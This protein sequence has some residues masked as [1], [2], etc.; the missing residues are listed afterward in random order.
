MRLQ[1]LRCRVSK[2]TA[3]PHLP[4][5]LLLLLMAVSIAMLP[6]ALTLTLATDKA[7]L[8]ALKDCMISVRCQPSCG[9][10]VSCAR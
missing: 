1:S 6:T 8:L 4:A 9:H 5:M 7:A 3:T 2:S 10:R